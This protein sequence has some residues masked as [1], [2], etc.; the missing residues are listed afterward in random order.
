MDIKE[1]KYIISE[2]E[3]KDKVVI[4]NKEEILSEI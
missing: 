1:L 2:I 4:E 3:N